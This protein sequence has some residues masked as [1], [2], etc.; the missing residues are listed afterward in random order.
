MKLFA[1]VV[2]AVGCP[3]NKVVAGPGK[4]VFAGE[5]T[6]V[7]AE[8]AGAG[9]TTGTVEGAAVACNAPPAASATRKLI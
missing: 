8:I 5:M 1:D 6:V 4:A 9:G 3:T 7:A 2:N